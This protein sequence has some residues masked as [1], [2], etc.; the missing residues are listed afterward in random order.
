MESIACFVLNLT[1]EGALKHDEVVLNYQCELEADEIANLVGAYLMR[2]SRN[3]LE[4][5]DYKEASANLTKH[6]ARYY[7]GRN[8]NLNTVGPVLDLIEAA[9]R[10]LGATVVVLD[11]IHFICRNEKNQTEAEANAMQRI[12]RMAQQYQV[13]FIVVG[14]PR[15]AEQSNK[16]KVVHMTDWKGSETGVSDADAIFAIHR[17]TIKNKDPLNPPMDDYEP[18]TEIHLL[19]ARSKGDGATFAILQFHGDVA[20]FREEIPDD[21]GAFGE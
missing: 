14:Q 21:S 17:N 10:R 4:E 12:K 18:R 3:H 19:G 2:K 11:H 20:A 8:A 1:V 13:K 7:V 9:I 6:N 16:G 5:A 15:K